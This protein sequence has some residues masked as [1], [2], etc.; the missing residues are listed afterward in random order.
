MR[1]AV[2]VR[3]TTLTGFIGGLSGFGFFFGMGDVVIRG[4][5]LCFHRRCDHI[6]N[7]GVSRIIASSR[8]M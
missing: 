3:I 4:A 8:L 7:S 5:F 6:H 1:T 2:P